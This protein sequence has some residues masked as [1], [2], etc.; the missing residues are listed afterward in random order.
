MKLDILAIGAHPDDIELSCGGTLVRHSSLGY[1]VGIL[2]LTRGE[3][4][5]RGTVPERM[6]EADNAAKIMG[7]AVREN[8]GFA[9]GFFQNDK[10]HQL[11]VIKM[12][13][14]YKP[15][16][17]LANA[18]HDRHPDH[19]TGAELAEDACFLSGLRMIETELDGVKQDAWRPSKVYHYIQALYVEPDLLINVSDYIEQ[20][21]AAIKAYKSQF[22]Q[23]ASKE[24]ST[25]I[26]SPDFIPFLLSRMQDFGVPVGAKYAEGFT[27]KTKIISSNFFDLK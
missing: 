12:I 14:K 26:S 11:E 4:G 21:V 8:L 15:D 2:D 6:E 20:K 23:E 5:T 3:L 17:V 19:K 24:P 13:R 16:I 18:F 7:C 27:S 22:Y 9:D 25:F 1:K 10:A